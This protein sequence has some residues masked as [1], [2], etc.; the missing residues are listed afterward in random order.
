MR[1]DMKMD[2]SRL[3]TLRHK[4]SG[5]LYYTF[6]HWGIEQDMVPCNMFLPSDKVQAVVYINMKECEIV[7][8]SN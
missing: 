8:D 4:V 7:N 5:R 3:I 2:K 1:W 6:E